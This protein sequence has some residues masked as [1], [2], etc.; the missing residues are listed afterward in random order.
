MPP[1]SPSERDCLAGIARGEAPNRTCTEQ[2][3]RRLLALG[4]IESSPTC[5]LP[6]AMPTHSLR[7][8]PSGRAALD[9][10]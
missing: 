4:L 2:V 7:L 10:D 8:T 9:P 1:L 6:L 5:C 3:L